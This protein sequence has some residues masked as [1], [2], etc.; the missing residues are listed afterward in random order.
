M[1]PDLVLLR[2]WIPGAYYYSRAFIASR[3]IDRT[4]EH[5]LKRG[6]EHD[7][8]STAKFN[9]A[10]KTSAV[11]ALLSEPAQPRGYGKWFILGRAWFPRGHD[12]K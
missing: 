6:Y 7:V 4:R 2:I 11:M 1:R 5:E 10:K 12:I 8:Q 9:R 3:A